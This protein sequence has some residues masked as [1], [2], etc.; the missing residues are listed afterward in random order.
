MTLSKGNIPTALLILASMIAAAHA[1]QP[2][3]APATRPVLPPR[4]AIEGVVEDG[5]G[6]RVQ[7]FI[8]SMFQQARELRKPGTPR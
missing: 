1:S 4:H 2:A 7:A 8:A 6:R 3:T 5:H